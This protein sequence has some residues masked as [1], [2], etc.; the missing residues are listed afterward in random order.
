MSTSLAITDLVKDYPVRS[1]ILNRRTATVRAVAGVSLAV[2]AGQTF[3]LVGETGC[4][5]STLGRCV[6]RLHD[7][8]GGS[9]RLDDDDILGYDES[10]L[11]AVRR[12]IQLVF[13]DPYASLN[14][15]L[16]VRQTLM[17]PLVIHDLHAGRREERVQEL[18]DQ[19]GLNP[20]HA[21][22]FP[23]EFSG[24]QRQRIGIARALAV[25]PEV[26]VLD[27]PVSA[28][29]VSVQAGVLNLLDDLQQRLGLTYLFIAHDL[30]VVRHLSH[31]VGVMYLGRMVE[32]GPVDT[33]F[34]APLHP[35]TQALLSAV[36]VPDPRIERTR[37]RIILTGDVP[38]PANP[39]SGC[40]FR[41]R[42]WKAQDICSAVEPQP[43]DAGAGQL[44]ACH[45]PELRTVL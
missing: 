11:R 38:S 44:V 22:R 8:D 19:V 42:C 4:G 12:R 30:S 15:R 5:K 40:R 7:S 35:Y 21:G 9:V 45:F 28:L 34:E 39:P 6:V 10:R 26:M 3:G 29:D 27:E 33:L 16:S 36:P 41:T 13:Q 2:D 17:E 20:T 31:R 43:V 1:G 25:E 23:H 32:Q 24:G 14:P 37:E 18:L